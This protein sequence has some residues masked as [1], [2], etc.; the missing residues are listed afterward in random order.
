M[1]GYNYSHTNNW[2]NSNITH[3]IAYSTTYGYCDQLNKS[4]P[5]C[6]YPYKR[7]GR[8]HLGFM[9]NI[10]DFYFTCILKNTFAVYQELLPTSA[11]ELRF[12]ELC[13]NLANDLYDYSC[14]LTF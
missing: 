8:G 5:G 6:T 2:P 12:D 1:L 10:S 9:G 13:L 14:N 7:G 11:Q 3:Q 4:L